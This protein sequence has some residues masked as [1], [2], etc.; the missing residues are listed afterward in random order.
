[1]V[2]DNETTESLRNIRT[3]LNKFSPEEQGKLINWG[4]ALT[5]TALRRWYFKDKRETG[6][7]PIGEYALDR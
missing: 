1:M 6:R 4:Y 3:R 5:D 7:W 2:R